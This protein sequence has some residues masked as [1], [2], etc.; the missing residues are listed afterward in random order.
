[1]AKCGAR[2]LDG[3]GIAVARTKVIITGL[4]A[5]RRIERGPLRWRCVFG[6]PIIE[7]QVWVGDKVQAT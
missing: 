2:T 5:R 4:T 1:M 3:G 7:K 6:L